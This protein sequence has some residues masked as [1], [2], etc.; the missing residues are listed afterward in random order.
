MRFAQRGENRLGGKLKR[1]EAETEEIQMHRRHAD[2]EQVRVCIEDGEKKVREQ[3]DQSPCKQGIGGQQSRQ[4][5]NCLADTFQQSG[6]VIEAD[7]RL[8]AAC[9]A[10]DRKHNNLPHGVEHGHDADVQISAEDLQCAV[11]GNLYKAVCDVH[12]EAGESQ[13]QN[14]LYALLLQMQVL[15]ADAQQR[16]GTGQKSERPKSRDKL[17]EDGCTRCTAHAHVQNKN[18][19]WI[20]NKIEHGADDDG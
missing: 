17:R 4:K 12:R 16:F 15:P 11:A 7:D 10:V 1:H 9:D 19:D 3:R 14:F 20:E 6:T 13:R 2:G 5:H 8:R 18:K